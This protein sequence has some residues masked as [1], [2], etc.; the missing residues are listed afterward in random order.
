MSFLELPYRYWDIAGVD[1]LSVAQ[2]LG[3]VE[4]FASFQSLE[5]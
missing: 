3:L 5:A 1:G 2:A 4:R